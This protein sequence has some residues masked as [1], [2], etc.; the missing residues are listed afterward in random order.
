MRDADARLKAEA[1]IRTELFFG[2]ERPNKPEVSDVEVD[3]PLIEKTAPT[4]ALQTR[5]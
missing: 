5:E 2:S 4:A 1:F 3:D